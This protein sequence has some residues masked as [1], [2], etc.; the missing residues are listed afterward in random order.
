MSCSSEHVIRCVLSQRLHSDLVDF[1]V[2]LLCSA[3]RFRWHRTG[4]TTRGCRRRRQVGG[5][6]RIDSGCFEFILTRLSWMAMQLMVTGGWDE[7]PHR[8]VRC[9]LHRP[10]WTAGPFMRMMV[11][12]TVCVFMCSGD[13]F[14]NQDVGLLEVP[15]QHASYPC[16]HVVCGSAGLV[17]LMKFILLFFLPGFQPL[18]YIN[19]NNMFLL[20]PTLQQRSQ[21]IPDTSAAI[22]Y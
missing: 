2:N 17:L 22:V 21:N 7:W 11:C 14:M 6:R 4:C 18:V 10:G 3:T 9:F 1:G 16:K 5:K 13:V 19:T 15:R 20:P 12:W 8:S